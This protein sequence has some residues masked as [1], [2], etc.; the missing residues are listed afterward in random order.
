MQIELNMITQRQSVSRCAAVL[1]KSCELV[2]GYHGEPCLEGIIVISLLV[3]RCVLRLLGINERFAVPLG[4]LGSLWIY[5]RSMIW[6]Q[7]REFEFIWAFI[8]KG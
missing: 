5:G 1:S 3:L 8:N 6:P 7:V 4:L 2:V